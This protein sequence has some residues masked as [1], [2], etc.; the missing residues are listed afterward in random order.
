MIS[1]IEQA[2]KYVQRTCTFDITS[3]NNDYTETTTHHIRHRFRNVI[4]VPM[5]AITDNVKFF[6]NK[7]TRRI[8]LADNT[9]CFAEKHETIHLCDLEDSIQ[10]IYNISVWEFVKT[11]H[12][13][14]KNMDSMHFVKIWL[15][16]DN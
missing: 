12:K 7:G 2:L 8:V 3:M 10:E 15:K 6:T 14:E 5:I 1:N 16:K 13:M 4:I 9:V 11:W